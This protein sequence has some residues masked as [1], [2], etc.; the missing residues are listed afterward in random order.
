MLEN[1]VVPGLVFQSPFSGDLLCQGATRTLRRYGVQSF[2]P[3]FQGTYFVSSSLSL[4]TS[5]CTVV[6]QSPFSGDLL[7][8]R[9]MRESILFGGDYL[10]IPVFRGLTLLERLRGMWL[11][12][13]MIFQS[14]FSGDLLCQAATPL[15]PSPTTQAFN[16]RFQGTY[17]VSQASSKPRHVL[18]SIFQSPFSGDLL[19]QNVERVI[20]FSQLLFFQSPFSGDLLCQIVLLSAPYIEISMCL[21]I[22]VFRGLTLL[23][24]S[25]RS[26]TGPIEL[27]QSPFSGDLLCQYH[28]RRV[29]NESREDLS[30]PV[31]RGL[32]LL[33]RNYQHQH[34]YYRIPFNPRFQGTYF[35]RAYEKF[36]NSENISF[37]VPFR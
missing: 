21:S 11:K 31:F 2:N 5:F 7:C 13:F 12:E 32:T 35:V 30:I 25:K 6:F 26:L 10:S 17:F 20:R 14:P 37:S 28:Q 9:Y 18:K 16:P 29:G 8:Q 1:T 19:C 23:A 15:R 24:S 34:A 22:P 33:A 27:F 3:R 4:A 36:K